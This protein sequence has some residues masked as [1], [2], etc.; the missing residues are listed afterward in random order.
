MNQVEATVIETE[1]TEL[2]TLQAAIVEL[3][4]SQLVLVGG[5]TGSIDLN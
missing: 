5:G 4:A 2:D 1:A 3:N